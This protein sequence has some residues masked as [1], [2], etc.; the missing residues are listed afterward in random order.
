[1][2][3]VVVG[4]MGGRGLWIVAVA[5]A[6]ASV[7][8]DDRTAAQLRFLSGNLETQADAMQTLFPEGRL[9]TI[10]LTG[11]AWSHLEARRPGR[12]RE[13]PERVRQ[14]LAL[15]E[16][17]QM[18]TAFSPAGGLP[19]GMFY[20][21]W[22]TQLRLAVGTDAARDSLAAGCRRLDVA[23][24][25]P[26]LY[27]DSYPGAAWPADTA[28]GAAALAGC[29]PLD[30]AFGQTSRQWLGRVRAHLDPATGLIPH[31]SRS[32]DA[33]GSSIAL[34]IP[35]VAQLDPV[36]ARDQQARFRKRF[37][38]RWLGTFPVIRE[39]PHGVEG[40]GDVDSGPV[41][42]GVSAPASVVG[43][44]AARATGDLGRAGG[45]RATVEAFGVPI[46]WRGRRR[47]AFGRL[48]V[49]DAFLAW[50]SS[51]PPA[52]SAEGASHWR[53]QWAVT[54]AVGVA[55]GVLLTGWTFRK[56]AKL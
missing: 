19:R 2:M 20:E 31:D 11:L 22:T 42:L 41:V 21:A 34:M 4:L 9:F 55:L 8:W 54:S 33:R 46:T 10:A 51:V 52:P 24:Q 14:A 50:A 30:P 18:R 17:P 48:P 32:P 23:L 15:A 49:G 3:G 13:A 6:P 16:S 27:L 29:A 5:P 56:K 28:V 12:Y 45:L 36:F 39:Y 53:R 43:I 26:A 47:Y 40:A 37:E 1:M 7:E 25:A 38:T 44:G 35:F